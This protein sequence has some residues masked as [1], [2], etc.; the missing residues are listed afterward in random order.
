MPRRSSSPAGRSSSA[1]E[2]VSL[3][4]SVFVALAMLFGAVL[5]G[6]KPAKRA[7]LVA[8]IVLVAIVQLYSLSR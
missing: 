4:F 8:I 2:V 6:D 7:A 3:V 5:S 1:D